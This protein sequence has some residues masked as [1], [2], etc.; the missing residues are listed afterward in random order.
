MSIMGNTDPELERR[1][2]GILEEIGIALGA[3]QTDL[4]LFSTQLTPGQGDLQLQADVRLV[5]EMLILARQ[6]AKH[7]KSLR[8]EPKPRSTQ[9]VFKKGEIQE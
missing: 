1:F 5:K 3:M 6:L 7:L 8:E 9:H 2:T 4:N